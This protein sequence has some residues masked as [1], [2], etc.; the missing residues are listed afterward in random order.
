MF[1][2][3]WRLLQDIIVPPTPYE[4]S[5]DNPHLAQFK[6]PYTNPELAGLNRTDLLFYSGGSLID[7]HGSYFSACNGLPVSH[8]A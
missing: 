3:I 6:S 1:D 7:Q 2:C 5:A 8:S 4:Y